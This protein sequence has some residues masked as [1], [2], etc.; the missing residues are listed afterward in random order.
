[1]TTFREF[2]LR[3]SA[4]QKQTVIVAGQRC[5]LRFRFNPSADR[6]TFDL[7]IG[8]T[9]VLFGRRIVL[10][11]DLLQPFGFGIGGLIAVSQDG[12]EPDYAALIERRVRLYSVEQSDA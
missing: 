10:G 4:N 8:D 11:A 5:T 3:D 7:R 9:D 6:W 12:S 1:V 2:R